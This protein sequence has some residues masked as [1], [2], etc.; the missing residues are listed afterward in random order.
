MDKIWAGSG[1]GMSGLPGT[2][3]VPILV[4][5]VV[6]ATDL[7]TYADVTARRARGTP[8][9]VTVGAFTVDTPAAWFLG[10]GLLWIDFFPLCVVG[11][12]R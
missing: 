3:W 11:R 6:L 1:V 5:L 10:R 4:L 7:W 8:V 12:G 2:A 9:V